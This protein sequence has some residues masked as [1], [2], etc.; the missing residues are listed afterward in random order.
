MP[1]IPRA[2]L[3]VLAV[4]LLALTGCGSSGSKPAADASAPTTSP[5][6]I[7]TG[8]ADT[9]SQP[10]G[11]ETTASSGASDTPTDAST[12]CPDIAKATIP[13][14]SWT[15]PITMDVDGKGGSAGFG[16]TK[17][18]GTMSVVVAG[19]SVTSGSWSVHWHSQGHA[20]TG[21]AAATIT[22]TGTIGGT[23]TGPA[24]KPVLPGTWRIKGTATITKPVHASSPVD[25]TGKDS[26]TMAV[27]S[28]VCDHVSGTFLPSFNSKDAAA[29][30]TGT[31]RWEGRRA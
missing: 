11:S 21:Q 6:V 4:P 13:D 5:T 19:G 24:T 3:A 23:V 17:G 16:S 18:T 27:S 2:S 8:T 22:L 7:D 14:G 12:A 9:P 10:T 20:D 31:A 26:E 25:D 29:T 30:F 1:R 28:T 15:G